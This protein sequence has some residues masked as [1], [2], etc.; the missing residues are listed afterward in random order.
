MES[1]TVCLWALLLLWPLRL[2]LAALTT[3]GHAA[4]DFAA[5]WQEEY[6]WRQCLGLAAAAANLGSAADRLAGAAPASRRPLAAAEGALLRAEAAAYGRVAEPGVTLCRSDGRLGLVGVVHEQRHRGQPS[7]WPNWVGR[8][9]A[10]GDH[11]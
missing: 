7:V 3:L 6:A 9:V 8:L 1:V 10:A 2:G 4:G 11:G 5:D